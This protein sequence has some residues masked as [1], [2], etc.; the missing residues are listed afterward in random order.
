MNPALFP[1]ARSGSPSRLKSATAMSEGE[2][3]AGNGVNGPNSAAVA[4]G[5]AA[6]NTAADTAATMSLRG[7]TRASPEN[8]RETSAK[9]ADLR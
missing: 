2:L 4:G 6:S 8:V 5:A 1:I 9:V 7:I 3:P